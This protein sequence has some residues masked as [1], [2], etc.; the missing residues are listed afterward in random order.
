MHIQDCR[1]SGGQFGQV[2]LERKFDIVEK[3]L[4][5]CSQKVDESSDSYLARAEVVWAELLMKK[6]NMTEVQ[7]YIT[8]R[9]SRLSMED[10]KRVLVEAGAEREDSELEMKRVS[11]AIRMLGSTFFQEYTSGKRD[12]SLRTYDHMAFG[13]IEETE[14]PGEDAPW[15]CDDPMDEETIEALAAEDDDA[16]L[17]LQFENAILDTV[18]EDKDL[19]TFFVS[20]QDARRRLQEKSKFRGFWPPRP[21]KG[22]K[23]G[24]GKGFKGRS[25]GLAQRIANSSCRLC[26]QPGHWK[27]ECPTRQNSTS[28][29][30]T[31]I[32]TSVVVN[33]ESCLQEIPTANA[34]TQEFA[35]EASFAVYQMP[36]HQFRDKLKTKLWQLLELRKKSVEPALDRHLILKKATREPVMEWSA[37]EDRRNHML[38]IGRTR[39]C[40]RFGS[41]SNGHRRSTSP[42]IAA[43]HP[44]RS[45]RP[46]PENN[47]SFGFPFRKSSNADQQD[48]FDFSSAQ[49]MVQDCDRARPN[50]ILTFECLLKNHPSSHRH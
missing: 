15:E 33:L 35:E 12:K 26:G 5:R 2:N 42:R 40:S 10:K 6:V 9:G 41:F 18:Q 32:P 21:F 20:Y 50:S 8:L 25:K 31:Q 22:G 47:M 17:V 27:A 7:A 44:P 48:S 39:G 43:E 11:A 29:D 1:N 36:N 28:N 46:N 38:C 24:K 19:A 16:S 45:E 34:E 49:N 23:K 3:A 4:F 14:E 30:S 37:T 13:A